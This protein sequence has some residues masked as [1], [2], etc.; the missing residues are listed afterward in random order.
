SSFAVWRLYDPYG[1]LVQQ[2]SSLDDIDLQTSLTLS[3]NYT[4]ALAGYA[5]SS[6]PLSYSFTPYKIVDTVQAL[7]LGAVVNGSITAPNQKNIFTFDLAAPAELLLTNAGSDT[8]EMFALTGPRGTEFTARA[9]SSTSVAVVPA[10]HYTLTVTGP[11]F[12]PTHDYAFQLQDLKSASQIQF[13]AATSGTLNPGSG[14]AAYAFSGNAGDHVSIEALSNTGDLN[15]RVVDAFGNDV[16]QAFFSPSNSG[17]VGRLPATGNFTLVI[18]GYSYNLLTPISFSFKAH[19]LI[20]TTSTLTLGALVDGNITTASQQNVYTFSLAAPA[21]LVFDAQTTDFNLIWSLTGPRGNETNGF[22]SFYFGDGPINSVLPAG[23]Y[24]LLIKRSDNLAGHYS[25]RLMDVAAAPRV[26]SGIIQQGTL[27]P[28]DAAAIYQFDVHAGDT[29]YLKEK[30]L[31]GGSPDWVIYDPKGQ[32][33]WFGNTLQDEEL[34]AVALGGT[35]TLMLLGARTDTLPVTYSFAIY[36]SHVATPI[37]ITPSTAQP[38][39]DLIATELSVSAV[40]QIQS[41]GTITV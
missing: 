19:K 38:A 13:E 36:T 29:I 35:Y 3:G 41:G 1:K 5:F 28:G 23:N 8:S 2:S 12:T 17:D 26:D 30:S 32:A 18:Y 39:P 14:A 9:L 37:Q 27:N 24:T 16:T 25:F 10:G 31:S 20:D 22:N 11:T 33:L 7:T 40:D 34:S 4:L 15:W 21:R 6:Q